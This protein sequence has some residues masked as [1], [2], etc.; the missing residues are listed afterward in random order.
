MD[1]NIQLT[2]AE[3][4]QIWGAYQNASLTSAVLKYFD[5]KTEDGE[6]KPVIQDALALELSH[7]SKLKQIFEKENFPIPIGFTDNDIN[8]D[9]PRL[10]TDNF[11]LH[12]AIQMGQLGMV[13]FSTAIPMVTREDIYIFYSEGLRQYNE[14]HQKALLIALTKGLFVKPPA[15]P[16]LKE[17]D[18]VKKQSFL[19][20]WFGERRPLTGME[21]T[22]LYSNMQRNNLGIATLT[23]F[24]QVAKSKEVKDY[25]VRGI[26][27]AKK[28]VNVFS[29]VLSEGDIPTPS[30]S[31]SMVTQANEVS[32]FSD[33]LIMSHVTAMITL[34]IAFYGMSITTNIRRDL[35]TTYTRLSAEIALYSEDGA[36]I[37]IDNEWLEEPPRMVDREELSKPQ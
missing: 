6:I 24:S 21:I 32:P 1:L 4:A 15:I 23:G 5:K 25:L 34:G 3:H 27:I 13:A 7:L 2:S 22:N 29:S 10:Y 14:I 8:A 28:H 19:T 36:N 18:F 37:M 16:L 33:K 12:Y 9:A 26:E 30:G 31:D 11:M 35:V 20:G 17:I